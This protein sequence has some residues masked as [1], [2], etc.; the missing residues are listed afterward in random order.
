MGVIGSVRSYLSS[1]MVLARE[2][3]FRSKL[4][5]S[6][7]RTVVEAIYGNMMTDSVLAP[8]PSLRTRVHGNANLK[9]LIRTGKTIAGNIS[10]L[11]KEENIPVVGLSFSVNKGD[12]RQS[13]SRRRDTAPV[14]MGGRIPRRAATLPEWGLDYGG[15][16]RARIPKLHCQER[17]KGRN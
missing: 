15:Y 16:E 17:W 4:L 2:L 11:L 9:H 1:P 14:P 7:Y 6:S 12:R 8:P 3:R 10:S 13:R 5:Y